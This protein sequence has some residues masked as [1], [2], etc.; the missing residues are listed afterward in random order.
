MN[1]SSKVFV[2]GLCFG[3]EH[4]TGML[5]VAEQFCER[6]F[7]GHE[8]VHVVV[9]NK[10]QDGDAYCAPFGICIPG[11]NTC[12]E[13]SGWQKGLDFIR[14]MH[15]PSPSDICVLLNDTVHRRNYATGGN[16]FFDDF[17]I[18]NESSSWPLRWAAGYLDDFPAPT[19]VN[20][21]EFSTWI[22][23]NFVVFNWACLDLIT[24]LVF[25]RTENDLFVDN[26]SEGFWRD[27]AP[28][29]EN[30]KAYISSWMFGAEDP[31]FPEYRLKW[32]RAQKLS[33]D[34]RDD[35]RK[36]AICILSEHYL[37]A[38]LQKNGVEIFDFNIY[39]KL[40]NRHLTPY[41]S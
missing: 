23:S 16:R 8:L 21:L 22:R 5:T 1:A 14:G 2:V 15:S 3:Q 29:S 24:P 32:I 11:D 25:P 20:G 26:V 13:F 38:R 18:R 33:E 28:L 19:T 17:V 35:F 4:V 30:W 6:N 41:Y 27:G 34:N 7:A 9:D 10:I 36:K 37:T 31:R 40:A 39:P 12:F